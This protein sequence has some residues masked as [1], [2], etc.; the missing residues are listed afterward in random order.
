MDEHP[1][2]ESAT[3][4]EQPTE[5]GESTQ[6]FALVV[7]T[8]LGVAALTIGLMVSLV[9]AWSSYS[10]G[11]ERGRLALQNGM[12]VDDPEEWCREVA[13]DHS[14]PGSAMGAWDVPWIW[15]C[16]RALG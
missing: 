4:T 5:S 13:V 8:V 9:V 10:A 2:I 7:A 15:G 3:V 14:R 6:P 11:S 16:H 1:I 12:P